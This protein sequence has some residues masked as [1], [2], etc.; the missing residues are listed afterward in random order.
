MFRTFFFLAVI[1]TIIGNRDY[2]I[3]VIVGKGNMFF[4]SIG[5]SILMNMTFLLLATGTSGCPHRPPTPPPSPAVPPPQHRCVSCVVIH[6][7]VAVGQ[8]HVFGTRFKLK[9]NRA[10]TC[11]FSH[12]RLASKAR[13]TVV[14][15]TISSCTVI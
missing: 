1:G 12:T 3:L 8:K 11:I 5:V 14:G 15:V 7:R 6:L 13:S 4:F 2:Q 10:S 9:N